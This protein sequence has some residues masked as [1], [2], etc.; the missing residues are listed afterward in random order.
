MSKAEQLYINARFPILAPS[1]ISF[2]QVQRQPDATSCGIYAAAFAT[3]VVLG[4]N[5]CEEK[6]SND[7]ESMRRHFINIIVTNE[8]SPFPRQ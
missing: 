7:V 1:D 2:P 8:L 4:K 6:Y 5:P 3:D